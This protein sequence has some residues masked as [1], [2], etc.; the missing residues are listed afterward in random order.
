MRFAAVPGYDP[1]FPVTYGNLY[2]DGSMTTAG[3]SDPFHMNRT[4][5]HI[6]CPHVV[7]YNG[8]EEPRFQLNNPAYYREV[9]RSHSDSVPPVALSRNP[10]QNTLNGVYQT[11]TA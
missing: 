5:K 8:I 9:I 4:E 3:F 7:A 6:Q 10:L 1:S 11:R 2:G